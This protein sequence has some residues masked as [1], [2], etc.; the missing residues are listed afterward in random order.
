MFALKS[1]SKYLFGDSSK[2]NVVELPQGQLYIV[3]PLS[4]KGY[5]ELIF[6]DAAAYI[7]RTGQEFQYQLVVQRAYEEG[8]A[9]LLEEEEGGT[10]AADHLGDRDEKTFLLDEELHFRLDLKESADIVCAWRDLSGD[11][12]DLFEFVCGAS[13]RPEAATAFEL[14]AAQ[15]QYERKYR[16]SHEQA[17]D[18]DLKKF[19][20]EDEP[21]IPEASPI[22]SPVRSP[23]FSP[24]SPLSRSIN[25]ISEELDMARDSSKKV[26]PA[27]PSQVAN[28]TPTKPPAARNAPEGGDILAKAIAELHFYDFSSGTFVLQDQEVQAIVVDVGEWN[29]WLQITGDGK[30]WFGQEVVPDINPVF[31]FEYLS[32]IFNH[33][34]EGSAYSWLLKFDKRESEEQFQEGLMQA[35]W[36]HLNQ[37]KWAKTVKDDRDYVL[38]AFND[39]VLED[40]TADDQREAEAREEDEEEDEEYDDANDGQRSEHYD[41]DEDEDEIEIRDKDGNINSQLAVG[42]KVDR[43]FVVRG[44]KIGVFKHTPDNHLAFSTSINKVATP[45]G[46]AFAPKKVML[47]AE[48]RD[49]VLQNEND[50][51]SLY[52]MDLETGKVVDEWKVHDDI[53]VNIYAPESKFAQNTGAQ[54][55]LGLSSNSLYRIDPRLSGNKLVDNEWKQIH[56]QKRLLGRGDHRARLHRRRFEQGRYP[57]VRSSRH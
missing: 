37:M 26:A 47:H 57:H 33:Y 15:C 53:P 52:R 31:N 29:Y 27:T 5:S 48:D 36:E 42:G 35:L 23:S 10:G 25:N 49:M 55:F 46:K 32:F 24:S 12:G 38:N 6:K 56:Q 45:K 51:H 18:D 16:K 34:S 39:L 20:F 21:A 43:S 13:T 8:E 28:Q 2:E 9:E 11:P 30:Q 17:T 3:R 7:R 22:S 54:T 1:L 50:P 44:D 19:A 41:E 14:V 40:T 4:P